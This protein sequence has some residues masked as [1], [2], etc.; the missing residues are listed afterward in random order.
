MSHR[1]YI[2]KKTFSCVRTT[3]SFQNHWSIDFVLSIRLIY[4]FRS[5]YGWYVFIDCCIIKCL[6]INV[7]VL[8]IMETAWKMETWCHNRCSTVMTPS[9]V[10][11]PT[12]E[13]SHFTGT[14]PTKCHIL[15][16]IVTLQSI[17]QSINQSIYPEVFRKNLIFWL[18]S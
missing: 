10:L 13:P 7:N 16:R 14:S 9:S 12:C 5:F 3:K 15:K 1:G 11:G 2:Y 17:N 8:C 4:V 6:A 18:I